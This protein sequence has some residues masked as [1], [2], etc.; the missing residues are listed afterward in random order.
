MLAK[1]YVITGSHACRTATLM[2]EHKG[3]AYRRVELPTGLHPLLVRACGFAGNSTPIRTVDGAIHHQLAL[4]DRLGT[5]PAL[6]LGAE[7]IQTNREIA[8]FLE[9]LQPEPS[10]F[11]HEPERRQAVEHAEQWGDETLQ[12]AA[13]RVA[14]AADLDAMNMRGADG[15]LGPLLAKSGWMRALLSR[16]AGQ[17]FRANPRNEGALLRAIP[18]MLDRVDAWIG[19]GVLCAEEL[20]VADFTIA[21]SLALLSYHSELSE[22]ISARPVGVLIDR[23]L[24]SPT[25][26]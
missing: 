4:L 17:P 5:V 10:L 13:R 26:L 6:R 20:N 16:T 7:R 15:R 12:M 14:L 11:P 22:Q 19:E 2:L 8:R 24:P 21:P 3:I 18:S 9:P 1:V 23:L 25:T